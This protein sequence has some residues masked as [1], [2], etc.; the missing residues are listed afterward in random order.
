MSNQRILQAKDT[1]NGKYG[2]AYAVIEG[3]RVELFYL[4]DF[5]AKANQ[6]KSTIPRLGAYWDGHKVV[7][8]EG[9]WTANLR[10]ITD[11]F[12]KMITEADRTHKTVYFDIYVTNDD[13]DSESGKHSDIFRN[14][15]LDEVVMAKLDANSTHLDEALSGTFDDHT[16][17]DRFAF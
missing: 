14:C 12:R 6:H 15:T 4:V 9:K 1:I 5:E 11:Q 7:G 16:P 2:T 13:P 3:S 10:Y 8:A 17:G